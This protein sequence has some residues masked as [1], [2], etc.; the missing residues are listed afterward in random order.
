MSSELRMSEDS[1]AA[2]GTQHFADE[3][4]LG[5]GVGLLRARGGELRVDVAELLRRERRVVGADQ[6]IGVGAERLDLGF[7][8]GHLLA[9]GFDL[10]GEPFARRRAPAPA[11]PRCW[12]TR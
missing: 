6:E 4:G 5:F 1:I 7:G 11:W 12:R 9:H 8:V 3:L 2:A 10:A